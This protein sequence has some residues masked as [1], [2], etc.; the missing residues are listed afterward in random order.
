MDDA[1]CTLGESAKKAIF[2]HLEI[3]FGIA[4]NDIPYNLETFE[5]GLQKIFG[6]GANFLEILIM[7]KL[8]E[9]IGQPLKWNENE[10]FAFVE[11]VSAAKQGFSGN[12][13]VD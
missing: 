2:Y 13:S 6:P 5:D 8:H 4:R 10:K 9:K 12:S 11:Y 7:R 3:K 1:F